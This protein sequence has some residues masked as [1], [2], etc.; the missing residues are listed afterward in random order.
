MNTVLTNLIAQADR[1]TVERRFEFAALPQGWGT[2]LALAGAVVVCWAIVWMYRTEGRRGASM[3]VRMVLA[4]VRCV[5]MLLLAG[6]LLQPVLAT[7]LHRWIDSYCI[8]LIDDSSSMDLHDRYRVDEDAERVRSVMPPEQ[9]FPVRRAD[10]VARLLSRDN[11]RLLKALAER[12]RVKVYTFSDAP[13]LVASLSARHEAASEAS[14][15]GSTPSATG[16]ERPRGLKPTDSNP[17]GS[18]R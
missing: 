1:T 14:E 13:E 5:V 7:Y 3:R 6:I 9:S 8:V 10:V 11:D 17:W 2:V 12:N 18:G 15:E 16:F 4:A